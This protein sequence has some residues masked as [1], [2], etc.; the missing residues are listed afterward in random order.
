MIAGEERRGKNRVR[1]EKWKVKWK[2]L[3][4]KVI[5]R[6]FRMKKRVER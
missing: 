5:A 2:I 1:L 6:N 3:Y 4:D